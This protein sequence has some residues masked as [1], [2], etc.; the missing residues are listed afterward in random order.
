MI[1]LVFIHIFLFSL[2]VV[3]ANAQEL[4]TIPTIEDI[5]SDVSAI[6]CTEGDRLERVKKL[7]LAKGASA[8]SLVVE[9]FKKHR[10]LVVTVKGKGSG[11]IVVGAH[12]DKVKKGCGAI[13][14]WSG[15]IV[16]ANL[17]KVLSTIGTTKTLKFVAFDSE[18]KGLVG[19]GKMAKAI[20]KK[21]LRSYCAMVNFDSFGISFPQALPRASTKNLIAVAESLA[22]DLK[23]TF[24]SAKI[25]GVD[26]D[27]SSFKR[28]KIPSI[29]FHGLDNNFPA[30]IHSELD[31]PALI[32]PASLFYGYRF[33]L[34]FIYKLDEMPCRE[35]TK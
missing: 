2:L 1:R 17:Y 14:N 16:L 9:T 11:T 22:K 28:R 4:T 23:L 5:R 8:E 30:Y 35:E 15:I 27:S 3:P 12:Y 21:D 29:T 25:R 10:N 31:T 24:S 6:D 20:P 32:K 13:D 18:E 34:A 7:F 33:G 19:S 26:A